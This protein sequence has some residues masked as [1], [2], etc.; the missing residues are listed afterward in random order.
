M[1]RRMLV[2]AD[3]SAPA[4]SAFPYAGELAARLDAEVTILNVADPGESETLAMHRA[5]VDRSS[6][7]MTLRISEIRSRLGEGSQHRELRASGEVVTGHAVEEILGYARQKGIDL[8]IMS[9]HGHTGMRHWALGSVAD[10]V[11]QASPVPLL[12]VRSTPAERGGFRTWTDVTLVVPLDGSPL[13]EQVLP[14]VQALAQ[15]AGNASPNVVLV[16]I[17]EPPGVPVVA[18]PQGSINY[19]IDYGALMNESLESCRTSATQYLAGIENKLKLTGLRV[20]SEPLLEIT[21]D[22][23]EAIVEYASKVPDSL[24]V[25]ATHGRSGAGR[26]VYGSVAH[27]VLIGSSRPILLVRTA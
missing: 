10:K 5:Y 2:P 18:W 13:A 12:L 14:H 6:Q 24:V 19:P 17:C 3:G 15:Q 4:E 7:A 25:M 22:P 16:R 8:I 1:Y 20:R 9:T 27:K 23:A 21:L 11:L 26:W